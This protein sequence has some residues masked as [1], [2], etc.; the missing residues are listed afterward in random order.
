MPPKGKHF[1]G[2]V[3]VGERGQI[4]IPQEA[5]KLFKI[6]SGD[7]LVIL[8]DEERGLAIVHQ[9][10]IINFISELGVPKNRK[11]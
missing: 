1:F 3:T 9:R 4:V 8:G 6:C 2:S 7:K 5:R 11:D 10:D